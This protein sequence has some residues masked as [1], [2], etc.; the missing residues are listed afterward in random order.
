MRK[1]LSIQ[2][3]KKLIDSPQIATCGEIPHNCRLFIYDPSTTH[4][5]LIDSG[6]DIS[7]IPPLSNERQFNT[8]LPLF[9]ANET[10][11]KTFGK[12]TLS[13]NLGLRRNF[14]WNFIIAD[15]SKPILGADFLKEFGLL[16]DLKRKRLLDPLTNLNSI[17]KVITGPSSSLTLISGSFQNSKIFSLLNK[18]KDI[19]VERSTIQPVL[20]NVTHHILTKGPPVASRSRRLS[21]DKLAIAKKEF[22]KLI[23]LG[24]CRPSESAWSSPLHLVKKKNGEWRPCGDYRGLNAQTIPDRYPIPYLQDFTQGMQGCSVFSTLDLVRAYHQIPVEPAHIPQTAIITPFGL[25]EFTRMTFGMRN[26]AQTFQ[27]FVHSILRGFDFVFSYIDDFI[28]ASKNQ[29]E[30]E[31]HLEK[32]FQRFREN[33]LVI[34][35]EKCVFAQPE[36]KFLGHFINSKGIRPSP[37][38]VQA[39]S[40]FSQPKTVSDMRRFLGML[41]FY[42]RFIPKA[43]ENQLLL[44]NFLVGAKKNDKSL[45]N[46]TEQ[47]LQAFKLAKQQLA[48]ACT[49]VHPIPNANLAI[50]V[51]ASDKAL[52]AAVHQKVNNIFEPLGFFSVKLDDA[53]QKYS[54]YDRELL[55][56]YSSIKHFRYLLEGRNFTLF[57]DHK[58]LIYAFQQNPAKA[59]PRQLRHLDFIGQFTTDIQHIAGK[60]NVVADALSRLDAICVPTVINFSDLADAQENDPELHMLMQNNPNLKF[61]KTNISGSEKQ[62][63]CDVST[64]TPRPFVPKHFRKAIFDSIH[65]LSHPGV[66]STVKSVSQKYIWKSMNKEVTVIARSC[67]PCQKNKVSRHVKPPVGNFPMVSNRFEEIHIDLIGPLTISEGQRYCLTVIDRFTRWPEAIPIPDIRAT[68]VA[69]A[70]YN[71]WVSRFGTP[72][73]IVTDQGRQ[74]ESELYKELAK[75]LGFKNKRTTAYN[76]PANG[77][78]E[79]WHRTVKTAVK[80]HDRAD[81]TCVL[82]TVLLGLRTAFREDFNTTSAEMVYG[83][84]LRLPGDFIHPTNAPLLQTEF[85]IQLKDQLKSLT[86][87]PPSRHNKEDIFIF[88]DLATCSHAFVRTDAVRAPWQSPYEGPFPIITRAEHYF[89]LLIKGKECNISLK[90]LKPLFQETEDQSQ[91]SEPVSSD[92]NLPFSTI[93]T[94]PPIELT[95]SVQIPSTSS[96]PIAKVKI[97]K[98]VTIN[99]VPQI[100]IIPTTRSGRSVVVPRRYR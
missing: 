25:F 11:I 26:A 79:R 5:F 81:W 89:T 71:G 21:S 50:M 9:A 24:Y 8:G 47:S 49:L 76:P 66:R 63:Y 15:V 82:P 2:I 70:L 69:F 59:S 62:I 46:W 28:I 60:D 98:K 45:I 32:I 90:R 68:T 97:N 72:L 91:L 57:T 56:A 37:E 100:K 84:T 65:G 38:R 19:T 29:N 73:S 6:A 67:L 18:F 54:A 42:R 7:V 12:K 31:M 13:L 74:F 87:S 78:I 52:G 64:G 77:Y 40:E 16:V 14:N 96:I 85:I 27:R 34:N 48:D 17:G 3:F 30:H 61:E 88:K 23:D 22:E 92:R 99:P 94:F 33:G 4:H 35:V 10:R 75:L 51:D 93:Q 86:P 20:H 1:S 55:A 36:V 39:I 53:Q 41:N 58:P 44:N 95:S 83:E 43:A 80:C